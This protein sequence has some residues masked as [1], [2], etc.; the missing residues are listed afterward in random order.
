MAAIELRDLR[1]LAASA[2]AG[3]FARAAESPGLNASTISR[4]IALLIASL[5][6]NGRPLL[7]Y[8]N[9]QTFSEFSACLQG[10]KAPAVS[11]ARN[12]W[13]FAMKKACSDLAVDGVAV[14]V[15]LISNL[16]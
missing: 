7:V 6:P 12:V 13:S 5:W 14:T 9:Q 16:D 2:V 1:Y 15:H 3:N 11:R 4:R 10:A 8:P